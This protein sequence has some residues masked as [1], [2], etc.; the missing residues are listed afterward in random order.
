MIGIKQ[1]VSHAKNLEKQFRGVL[2]IAKVLE[3][4]GNLEHAIESAKETMAQAKNEMAL[5]MSDKGKALAERDN[6]REQV[7]LARGDASS[8]ITNAKE[9]AS[10]IVSDTKAEAE[11]IISIA[12]SKADEIV[13]NIS[14]QQHCHEVRVADLLS[15]EK[16]VQERVDAIKAELAEL[17]E[18]FAT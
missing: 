3:E 15:K 7:E 13:K 5:A 16:T 17:R 18:K 14:Y 12:R 10:A 9:K 6:A 11:D 4:F 2:E 1:A 8:I